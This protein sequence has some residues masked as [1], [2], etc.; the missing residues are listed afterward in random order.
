MTTT[1][2]QLQPGD[3]QEVWQLSLAAVWDIV[4][5]SLVD[6]EPD[7]PNMLVMNAYSLYILIAQ[8]LI[9]D[10]FLDRCAESMEI[11]ELVI[12][13]PSFF[14]EGDELFY[15]G[16]DTPY[17]HEVAVIWADERDISLYKSSERMESRM[18]PPPPPPRKSYQA[19][20]WEFHVMIGKLM[21][22]VT[23]RIKTGFSHMA[24]VIHLLRGGKKVLFYSPFRS[25][26]LYRNSPPDTIDLTVLLKWVRRVRDRSD[27]LSFGPLEQQEI[28]RLL[29]FS[30]PRIKPFESLIR[31]RLTRY[32]ERAFPEACWEFNTVN[33]VLRN[34]RHRGVE[35]GYVAVSPF[36]DISSAGYSAEAFRKAGCVVAGVQHG[37]NT[38]HSERGATPTLLTDLFGGLF[39]QW[40]EGSPA[41]HVE[42]GIRHPYKLVVAGSPNTAACRRIAARRVLRSRSRTR[43][44]VILYAPTLMSVAVTTAGN[45]I[46]WDGYISVVREICK[47]LDASE[48]ECYVKP[49]MAREYGFFDFTPY[50]RLHVVSRFGFTDYMWGA[51]YLIVDS[52]GGSPIYEAMTTDKPILAYIDNSNERWEP[53]FL[54]ALKER[55]IGFSDPHSYTEGVHEFVLDPDEYL[56][57]SGIKIT[58]EFVDRYMPAV[59]ADRMWETIRQKFFGESVD[60]FIPDECG[61]RSDARNG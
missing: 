48:H 31:R 15:S 51:D 8:I 40:G 5:R 37:G 16:A 20:W 44:K 61:V 35:M 36:F 12:D 41:E 42:L 2:E 23:S 27:L 25:S 47:I 19:L 6:E 43:K 34:L 39:F 21:P 9:F 28:N 11:E 46:P 1:S 18:D 45:N 49:L 55:V 3:Y 10:R 56:R 60:M 29:R 33:K 30:D 59:S 58:D 14:P 26:G 13:D 38:G 17:F 7:K 52:L 57:R 53:E 50:T 54:K 4:Q 22:W 24:N 32:L